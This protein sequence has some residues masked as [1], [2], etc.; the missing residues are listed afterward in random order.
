MIKIERN[1]DSEKITKAKEILEEEKRKSNGDYNKSEVLD[2]LKYVFNKKCYLCENKN[3][4]SY[5]IEHL[6]PHRNTNRDLKFGWNNL[7]LA[8]AHCN[9]IKSDKYENII[10]CTKIDADELISF[11][12]IGNFVWDEKI[13]ILPLNN[14]DEIKETVEL[15]QKIYEGNTSLKKLES[16]NIKKELRK[17]LQ[18]FINSINEYEESDGEDKEDAKI[19]IKKH[20]KSNSAFTAFKRWIVRDNKDMLSEFLQEDGVKCLI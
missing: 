9:N 20:L 5:N 19:L 12:K 1:L 17:E 7:F 15:L 8:C 18:D 2:A 13:E 6:K 10:D 3:I 11:R 14:S 16:A 4:T